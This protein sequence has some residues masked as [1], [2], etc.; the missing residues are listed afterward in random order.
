[1]AWHYDTN[2]GVVSLLL[3]TPDEG[4]DFEYV[5]YLREEN[6]EHYDAVADVFAGCSTRV[7]QPRM[8]PGSLL[9]FKG[10]RSL[11]R[12][13]AVGRT[14]KPRLIALMSY[15]RQPGMVFPEAT[16]RAITN[17]EVRVHRGS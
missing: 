11:H 1:M 7:Q 16:V 4:G 13:S 9:L 2:D 6:D 5:P 17:P 10:R 14:E 8:K 15:D 3:Q 12:V